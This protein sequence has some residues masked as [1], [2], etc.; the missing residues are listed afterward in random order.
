[1]S[2]PVVGIGASAGGLE[3]FS[4]LL[5]NLPANTGMAFLL[6][7]H[8]DPTH[9]SFLVEI[10]AKK[11]GMPIEEAR[12]GTEVSPDHVYVLPPNSTLTL[13]GDRL[14]LAT[15]ETIEQR[16]SPVDILFESLAER[17][18]NAIGV[19]LSGTGSDGAKGVQILKDA[20]GIIFAQ[21]E[22]SARFSGMPKSAIETGC[23][24]FI[25]SPRLISH[26]LI[27]MGGHSYLNGVATSPSGPEELE[28]PA[29]PHLEDEEQF[30]RVFRILRNS[31]GVDFAHY[32]R[33]TIQRRLS[34]RMA[35]HQ[36][37]SLATYANLL[38]ENSTEAQALFRDLLI[39]VTSFFRDQEMFRALEENIFP[40]L[41]EPKNARNPLRI[42]VPGCASGEEVY[43][44]AICLY[45]RIA[46]QASNRSIQIFGTDLNDA[47]IEQARAGYYLE[48]ISADV[49]AERLQ[50]FFTK[51]DDHYQIA[52]SIRDLCVFAKHNLIRDPPFSRLDLISC[53]NVLIYLDQ[54]LHR[55]ALSLFHYALK[56]RGFLVLGPSETVGQSPD[57]FEHLDDRHRIYIRK[58]RPDR[59][60]IKLDTGES[61]AQRDL[62]LPATKAVS[63]QFDLD[64]I[65]K[66]SDRLLLT[67]YAP[68]CVLVDEDLNIL[69]FRGET[70]LYLEHLPG[71]A[72]LNLQKLARPTLLV[73]LSTAISQARKEEAP[74][75]REAIT[76][77]AQGAT[78][79]TRLEVIP[80]RV[81]ES[82]APGFLILFE[83]SPHQTSGQ[84]RRMWLE[85]LFDK[86]LGKS[87]LLATR[88]EREREF[89][90]VKQELDAARDL[91]QTTIE[92][93]EA[94]KEELK[95]A[96]EEL[97]S[98][99]EEFQTT[100]EELET[101]KEEL[102][103][104][105]E[106]LVTTNDELRNR[107]RELNRTNDALQVSWDYAEAIIATVREPLLILNKELGVVRANR[108]FYEFFK[109]L[110]EEIE[111][112]AL[113]EIGE[114]QW[115]DSSLR[116]LLDKVVSQNKSFSDFEMVKVFPSIGKKALLLNGQRLPF[117]EK[118]GELC[119]L[120]IDDITDRRALEEARRA[121]REHV[122]EDQASDIQAL[123]ERDHILKAADQHKDEF[124]AMLAHELRNPLAPI[125]TTLDVLRRSGTTDP[126]LE[127]G[128]NIIDRQTRHLTRLV[129]D[130]LDVARLTRGEIL[131]RKE[132]ISLLDVLNHS[133]ETSRPAIEARKQI[134]KLH[135]P[136]EPLYIDGDFVRLAQVFSNL[137]N[138]ASKY[139]PECGEIVLTAE[140]I[141]TQAMVTVSD[142]GIGILADVLPNIFEVFAQADRSKARS[143]GGLGLG[144]TLSLRLVELH[145]GNIGASSDGQDMGSQFVVR[146]PVSQKTP[147]T[148][149]PDVV[150]RRPTQSSKFRVLVADDN[151][152]STQAI[153]RLL[154]LQG[155]DVRCAFDGASALAVAQEFDPDLILL[156]ISLPDIN[157]YEVLR[158]L[159]E[160]SPAAR[161]FVAAVTG[162]GQPE[163]HRRSREAGFDHHLVKPFGPD[164]LM[165]VLQ[166]LGPR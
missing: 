105:N 147:A 109:A 41:L 33:T 31:C 91:L 75:R 116:A 18:P 82:N 21:E 79:E 26:E 150:D 151:V 106:E 61:V 133:V 23:V 110:P 10:L 96:H 103:A 112:K 72:S 122:I 42:W 9:G 142:H 7:Q 118:R 100:N 102:Q 20:G 15:R 37:E 17:G 113:Q 28:A 13:A 25:L 93:Q 44:I 99:N 49:S 27:R 166:S 78:R 47:A 124:L 115:N 137:L 36:I 98:A 65:L 32:K 45:E 35:V 126:T 129:D 19:I 156:D 121:E 157:G 95:S 117:A 62:G 144:L 152:D 149:A 67:R 59:A 120:A 159:R 30:R 60:A 163:D 145:G 132:L 141:G 125:R 139:S 148:A 136:S 88:S 131:L 2:F 22:S 43:S 94:A 54:S 69:Q 164:V 63:D 119:L 89:L 46:E 160:Q 76:V 12:E 50:R 154:Q 6:V 146:L 108:G 123:V 162:F 97:L 48:N 155:H 81:P 138:N 40:T 135:L 134:L 153:S 1:V 8:L 38:E 107:N 11:T 140:S 16:R 14:H 29:P 71:L 83:D 86:L 130:L 34:R 57:F 64:R 56:P 3:A 52:R 165:A 66:E 39:C 85:D 55:R 84:K 70:S 53:R 74:V 104:A 73:A 111:N 114:H 127:W 80:I 5:A 92:E 4:Q 77:K 51:T 101:A 158:R 68:A 161:P 87:R 128:W 58:D 90:K 24:D 143:E